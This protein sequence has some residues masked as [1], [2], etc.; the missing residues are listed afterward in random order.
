MQQRG[1]IWPFRQRNYRFYLLH[2]LVTLPVNIILH[3]SVTE[4]L[5]Y[6]VC[7]AGVFSAECVNTAIERICNSS[8]EAYDEKIKAIKDISA[9]GV[10]N[11]LFT[12]TRLYKK[13]KTPIDA[14]KNW[15]DGQRIF[16]DNKTW[17]GFVSMVVFC[18]IFQILCG[19]V[20]NYCAWNG[21]NDL[22]R[23]HSNTVLFNALFGACVGFIYMLCELPNSFLKRRIR[24]EPGRTGSGL[25]GIVFFLIDQIDS[26]VG[27]MLSLLLVANISIQKYFAY[28][29]VGALTHIGINLLFT[30]KVRKHI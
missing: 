15:K 7:I 23:N 25:V 16:G 4:H 26:L 19:W 14:G 6:A 17:I 2:I 18:M 5:I 20:C 9:G 13:H 27:V 3:F 24:I 22:Y 29:L 28:V 8:S 21:I 12:K 1:C 11:M 30:V 10:A